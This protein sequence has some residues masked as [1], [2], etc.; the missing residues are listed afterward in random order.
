MLCTLFVGP[1]HLFVFPSHAVKELKKVQNF[2]EKYTKRWPTSLK[3]L[4]FNVITQDQQQPYSQKYELGGCI[5]V[6]WNLYDP[7]YDLI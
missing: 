7:L 2:K 1:N 6:V 4:L 5:G 3:V